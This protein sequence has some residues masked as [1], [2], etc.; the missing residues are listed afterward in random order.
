METEGTRVFSPRPR[1]RE[2]FCS[3]SKSVQGQVTSPS[4][5]SLSNTDR[6]KPGEECFARSREQWNGPDGGLEG[7]S[8]KCPGSHFK[9][10]PGPGKANVT[11]LQFRSRENLLVLLTSPLSLPSSL[12]LGL[13]KNT[14]GGER[15]RTVS[16]P[17]TSR[18]G[19]KLKAALQESLGLVAVAL[20]SHGRGP[21]SI[22]ACGVNDQGKNGRKRFRLLI[23]TGGRTFLFYFS[24]T[25]QLVGS[26]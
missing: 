18:G 4:R 20:H 26:H 7:I 14:G 21:G 9:Y 24:S 15:G 19:E 11:L 5:K 17:P 10:L 6:G 22:P 23:V 2:P 25:V 12:L 3:K 1:R 16:A 8:W 13:G